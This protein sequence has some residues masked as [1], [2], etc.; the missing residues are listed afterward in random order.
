MSLP[1]F[2]KT[3]THLEIVHLDQETS[4]DEETLIGREAWQMRSHQGVWQKGVTAGGCRNSTG[5]I[6]DPRYTITQ[7]KHA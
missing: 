5:Q 1:D 4:K 7:N 3:F 2:V 6:F